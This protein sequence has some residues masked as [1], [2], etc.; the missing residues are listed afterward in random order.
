[1]SETWT[2]KADL[3]E[4]A[5]IRAAIIFKPEGAAQ[6]PAPSGNTP[7]ASKEGQPNSFCMGQQ[8]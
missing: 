7:V 6:Q 3:D 2:V 1:M 4:I 5:W 8:H